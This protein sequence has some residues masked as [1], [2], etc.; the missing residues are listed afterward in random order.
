VPIARSPKL[1]SRRRRDEGRNEQNGEGR[2]VAVLQVE[3]YTNQQRTCDR[4]ALIHRFV[5]A[6]SHPVGRKLAERTLTNAAVVITPVP[7]ALTNMAARIR[8]LARL[9]A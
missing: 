8:A 6:K 9:N 2:R 3:D 1:K 7:I 5:H 4:A